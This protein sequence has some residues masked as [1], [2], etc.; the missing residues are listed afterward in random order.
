MEC[1]SSSDSRRGNFRQAMTAPPLAETRSRLLR[2]DGGKLGSELIFTR[3][4]GAQWGK[5]H[6][7]RPMVEACRRAKIKP[8]I[9]FH[10][11]RHTHGSTLAHAARIAAVLTLVANLEADEIRSGEMEAGIA[12]AQH[13]VAEA[14]RLFGASR[15]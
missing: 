9:S 14:L 15:V 10:V 5:S 1:S 2:G 3:R 7:L 11:L 4:D 8:E 13:Y 6:Q 12:L